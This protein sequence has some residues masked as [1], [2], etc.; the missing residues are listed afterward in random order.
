MTDPIPLPSSAPLQ[1]AGAVGGASGSKKSAGLGEGAVAFKSLLDQLEDR[2]K[3]LEV[4]SRKDLSKDDLAGAIDN[5]RTSLEQML[6]LKD[7]LLEAWR[8]SQQNEP[9]P[10]PRS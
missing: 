3:A 1:G 7:Q 2:A 10:A 4:E 5:A 6:S 8:A 9:G